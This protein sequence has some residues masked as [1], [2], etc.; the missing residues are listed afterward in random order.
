MATPHTHEVAPSSGT[1]RGATLHTVSG[2]VVVDGVA[3]DVTVNAVSGTTTVRDLD[4]ALT[5]HREASIAAL[6]ADA[7]GPW[8]RLEDGT[9][10]RADAVVAAT[11]YHQA[12]E[13]LSDGVHDRV[14]TDDAS[15][16]LYRHVLALDVPHLAF[17]GSAHSYR[18]PLISEVTAAWLAG[19][20]LGRVRLPSLEEQR[21][22]AARHRLTTGRGAG[23][24][25]G[26][27]PGV[28]SAELDELLAELGVPLSRRTRRKQVLT[29]FDPADYAESLN[30]FR[31]SAAPAVRAR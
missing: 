2:D 12:A 1:D 22:V 19:V 25:T 23:A 16:L 31:R 27:L 14:R 26:H 29:P 4:G 9:R 13:F 30:R 18:S 20:L 17:I 28:S 7:D 8:V 24:R 21:R 11:G 6:G 5:V 15:I 10:L 3:G